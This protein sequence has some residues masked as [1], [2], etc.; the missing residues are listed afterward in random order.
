[1]T[2]NGSVFPSCEELI[3]APCLG[4]V[5]L[6]SFALSSPAKHQCHSNPFS[7]RDCL[8]HSSLKARCDTHLPHSCLHSGLCRPPVSRKLKIKS[9]RCSLKLMWWC[10]GFLKVGCWVKIQP[11]VGKL[12]I[13]EVSL[14]GSF[15]LE[16]LLRLADD[17]WSRR[18]N[19]GW[20]KALNCFC[21]CTAFVCFGTGIS[22]CQLNK[23]YLCS[24]DTCL[25]F[26]FFPSLHKDTNRSVS[27]SALPRGV[28]W[29]LLTYIWQNPL[30]TLCTSS[31]TG[32][33]TCKCLVTHKICN[34]SCWR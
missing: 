25:E 3:F 24:E 27:I 26:V 9:K 12:L 10:L 16:F 11:P 17:G 18:Y 6:C 23:L 33:L 29:T 15:L 4:V 21:G 19:K 20:N 22:D 13:F 7:C 2:T 32:L 28:R 1:M 5:L 30:A 34:C 14:H 8:R 31:D